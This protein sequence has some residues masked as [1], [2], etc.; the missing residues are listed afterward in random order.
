MTISVNNPAS[1]NITNNNPVLCEGNTTQLF[2]N[3]NAM[4]GVWSSSNPSVANTEPPFI[5][6]F[7]V[8]HGVSQGTATITYTYTDGNNCVSRGTTNITVN[9]RLTPTFTQVAAICTG[10][11]LAAL[12][13]TSTNGI[14][15]TWSPAL[16]NRSTTNYI[17]TPD[18][19]VCAY[20]VTMTITVNALPDLFQERLLYCVGVRTMLTG[21]GTPAPFN[22][23]TSSNPAVATV[24]NSGLVAGITPGTVQITFTNNSG[25]SASVSFTVTGTPTVNILPAGSL[26]FCQGGSVVLNA[27]TEPGLTY[28]WS[29]GGSTAASITASADGNY[30]LTGTNSAGCSSTCFR[31]G[32]GVPVPGCTNY[33]RAFQRLRG[34]NHYAQCERGAQITSG[35]IRAQPVLLLQ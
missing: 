7:V 35:I 22:P 18:F 25:C 23:W 26:A 17:F 20:P 16:N 21:S 28:S 13:T 12:P 27:N 14:T 8:A 6:N 24:D 11:P 31:S 2:V 3:V 19:G 34:S 4:S 15:G 29:P 10:E 5:S 1:V 33:F 9:P 32:D 30:T